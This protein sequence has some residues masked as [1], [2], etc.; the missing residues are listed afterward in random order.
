MEDNKKV[1]LLNTFIAS[2]FTAKTVS[3]TVSE[4]GDE[5]E[6]GEWNASP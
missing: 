6:S 4:P 1:E 2:V 5:K 3:W